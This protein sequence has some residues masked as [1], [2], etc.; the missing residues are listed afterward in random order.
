MTAMRASTPGITE[1][2]ATF[3]LDAFIVEAIWLGSSSLA[4]ACGD[5]SLR[6]FA[7]ED[8]AGG[9]A[10]SVVAHEGAILCAA[11][12]SDGRSVLTGGDD[13]R[14][15]RTWPTGRTEQLASFGRRWVEHV[16]ASSTS[17]AIACAAGKEV[18]VL[19]AGVTGIS[20]AFQHPSTVGGITF[21]GKG[22]RL[23]VSHYG[24]VSV[25]WALAPQS[26]KKHLPWG[27][28]HLGVTWSPDARFLV[29]AMQEN[30]LHG[31]RV[32]DGTSMHM[33]GYPAKTR[34]C[35]WTPKGEWLVT[36][37]ADRVV[38]WPFAGK[39]GPMG[40][41]PLELGPAGQLVTRVACHPSG[42]AIVAGYEDGGALLLRVADSMVA[43]LQMAVSAP[44]SALA[45]SACGTG[46][47]IG[48]EDGRL[49]ILF[50]TSAPA[51]SGRSLA[52]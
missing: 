14:L 1:S 44:V 16:V 6:F 35:S 9:P 49:T 20:H 43:V 51:A 48:T 2:G 3:G 40:K 17:G 29:T 32:D 46:F 10:A 12:H 8:V 30:A 28:S 18:C 34:S 52:P 33:Q 27:G 11:G 4:L 36:S 5:G 45:W 47:A 41:N 31:W 42:D 21:D 25:W 19:P 22:R 26:A 37:G 38:C 23:A 13:G 39:N 24:G 15:V 50:L 7:A